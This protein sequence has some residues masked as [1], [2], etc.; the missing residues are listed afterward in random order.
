MTKVQA[1]Q[2]FKQ[3][4]MPSIRATYERNGGRDLPARREAWN[5][6]TDM[7]C[8]D[9]QITERQ[10]DTWTHPEICQ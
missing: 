3:C 9:G 1:I 5:D 8:K 6:Y 4:I 2:E 7:L 10:Y